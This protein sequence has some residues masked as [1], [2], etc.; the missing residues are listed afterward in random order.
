MHAVQTHDRGDFVAALCLLSL[1]LHTSP[2]SSALPYLRVGDKMPLASHFLP[3]T[4]SHLHG[5]GA[6]SFSSA[7]LLPFYPRHAY[8][9]L[10]F[11]GLNRGLVNPFFQ[12]AVT[13][14]V[15]IYILR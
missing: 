3:T 4:T 11:P 12:T 8:A 13:R 1:Y 9:F 14:F 15:Y 6:V 7:T 10:L 2:S 5:L